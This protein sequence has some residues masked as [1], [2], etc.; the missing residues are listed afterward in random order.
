[1]AVHVAT[2]RMKKIDKVGNV[3]DEENAKISEMLEASSELR[4]EVDSTNANTA[5]FPT[6]KT[7]LTREMTSGYT[8][9]HLDQTYIITYN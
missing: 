5:G 4:V 1:M 6:L 9:R 2:F 3:V 7:Y 8:L